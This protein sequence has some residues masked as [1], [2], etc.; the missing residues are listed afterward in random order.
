M[1][2]ANLNFPFAEEE[3]HSGCAAL[4]AFLF[5]VY[6]QFTCSRVV[7]SERESNRLPALLGTAKD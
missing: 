4:V 2:N 3:Q 6:L 1:G 7:L 5:S